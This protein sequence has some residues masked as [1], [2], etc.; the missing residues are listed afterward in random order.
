MAV[1]ASAPRQ[2]IPVGTVHPSATLTRML[3]RRPPPPEWNM[4]LSTRPVREQ[5]PEHDEHPEH[6][7]QEHVHNMTFSDDDGAS[8]GSGH[9][10][11]DDQEMH[12]D[13]DEAVG[14]ELHEEAEPDNTLLPE[15]VQRSTV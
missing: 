4:A 9:D 7:L 12:N 10:N 1:T 13:A 2:V 15:G 11:L 3:P 6:E 8:I 5:E 14:G